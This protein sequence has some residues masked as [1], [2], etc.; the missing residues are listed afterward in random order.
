MTVAQIV[1]KRGAGADS[2][3]GLVFKE[4][5]TTCLG[6]GMWM[7]MLAVIFVGILV[8]MCMRG[9]VVMFLGMWVDMCLGMVV[10]MFLGCGLG[11]R[12]AGVHVSTH[13]GA[14]VYWDV[15]GHVS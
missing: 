7:A 11:Y 5:A 10:A 1:G 13:L 4:M 8:V 12:S 9:G 14:H 6:A 15:G 3:G 2:F